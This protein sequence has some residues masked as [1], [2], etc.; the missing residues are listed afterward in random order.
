[1]FKD[2]RPKLKSIEYIMEEPYNAPNNYIDFD[3]NFYIYLPSAKVFLHIS[4]LQ[5]I[6][7]I[8]FGIEI[9]ENVYLLEHL[10]IKLTDDD[11]KI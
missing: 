1:M 4:S 7:C 6:V 3:I 11:K 9:D 8:L 5:L 10:F 2:N